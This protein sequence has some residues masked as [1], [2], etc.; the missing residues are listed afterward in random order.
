[1]NKKP[2]IRSFMPWM[3]SLLLLLS[4]PSYSQSKI[5]IPPPRLEFQNDQLFIEYD[6]RNFQPQDVFTIGLLITDSA[7]RTINAS[8]L[9]GEIGEGI[10]GGTNKRIVWNIANDRLIL[11]E[12]V[13]VEITA[14]KM[15]P[16]PPEENGSAAE[17]R[18]ASATKSI[19]KSNM[20]VSSLVMPGLGQ[21][22]ARKN[23]T[24]L[25]MGAAGYGCVAGAALLNRQAIN[26]YADYKSSL[27]IDERE[28][29]FNN[30][31][32][33]DNNSEILAKAA[34]GIWAVNIIWTIFVT[35]K[36]K[37]LTDRRGSKRIKIYPEYNQQLNC[38]MVL[39]SYKF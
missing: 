32:K 25:L 20:L 38:T 4:L 19:S 35:D 17:N 22:K 13:F 28:N 2:A 18:S 27:D 39:L 9:S 1:M 3:T 26:T 24:Y 23:Y 14:K 11:D 37:E 7:G 10:S 6:I 8:S 29:L 12:D 30:S 36:S 16:V 31:V 15:K 21:S 33:Q 5:T 34:A